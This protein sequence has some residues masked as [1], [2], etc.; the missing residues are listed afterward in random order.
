MHIE[1]ETQ[2]EGVSVLGAEEDIWAYEGHGNWGVEKT[3]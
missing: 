1:G 2:A 3:T